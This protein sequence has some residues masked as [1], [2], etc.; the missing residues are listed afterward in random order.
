MTDPDRAPGS[1]GLSTSEGTDGE[2]PANDRHTDRGSRLDPVVA[3]STGLGAVAFGLVLG[4]AL[5]D[6]LGPAAVVPGLFFV[7]AGVLSLRDGLGDGRGTA[8]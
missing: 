3:A 6:P 2:D 8:K 4:A 5:V 7:L 1:D